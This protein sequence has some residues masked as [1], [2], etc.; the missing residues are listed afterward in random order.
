MSGIEKIEFD[1]AGGNTLTDCEFK[2][3]EGVVTLIDF[4]ATWCGPC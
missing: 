1:H 2:A 3:E 4:W